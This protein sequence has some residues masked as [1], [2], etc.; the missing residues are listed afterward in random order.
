MAKPPGGARPELKRKG[1]P[2]AGP[3]ARQEK[4]Q[5]RKRAEAT[6]DGAKLCR[7]FNQGKCSFAT[8]KCNYAHRCSFL[9]PNGEACGGQHAAIN[10]R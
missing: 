1:A 8:G 10:H 6:R 9:K 2:V 4:P 7:G 5:S 3:K